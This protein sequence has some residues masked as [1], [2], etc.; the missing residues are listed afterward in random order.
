MKNT[1]SSPASTA[2][3]SGLVP[4]RSLANAV[5]A[6]IADLEQRI[7]L[8]IGPLEQ[9]LAARL[10]EAVAQLL[11]CAEELAR[12]ELMVEGSTGQMR[13]HPMLKATHDLRREISDGLKD[14]VFRATN[15]A[16]VE[17]HRPRREPGPTESGG[18]KSG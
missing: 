14:L 1:R 16:I 5:E 12:S 10:R 4:A 11:A 9:A 18:E 13:P 6:A 3:P 7:P 2:Q 17:R 8:G 15:R